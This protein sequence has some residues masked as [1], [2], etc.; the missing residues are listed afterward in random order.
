MIKNIDYSR[1]IHVRDLRR[2]M[3]ESGE[4]G[5]LGIRIIKTRNNSRD[6]PHSLRTIPFQ[7]SS[8]VL[9]NEN[10]RGNNATGLCN[11][12]LFRS[13]IGIKT[14][15]RLKKHHKTDVSSTPLWLHMKGI[16]D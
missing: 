8:N 13:S 14:P 11:Q 1:N 10:L 4:N 9:A 2:R 12:W 7:E 3:Q 16:D 6:F 15:K 5:H